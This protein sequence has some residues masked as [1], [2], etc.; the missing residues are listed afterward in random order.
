MG[1]GR[2]YIGRKPDP[3]PVPEPVASTPPEPAPEPRSRL[4]EAT[5][6]A[7]IILG[8]TFMVMAAYLTFRG[9]W[10]G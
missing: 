7:L 8:A 5:L 3:P 1:S 6:M 2:N 10:H 9:A 4:A